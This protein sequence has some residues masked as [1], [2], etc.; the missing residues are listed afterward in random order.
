M[1]GNNAGNEAG[2]NL[3]PDQNLLMLRMRS[4]RPATTGESITESSCPDGDQC[5]NA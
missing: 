4:L 5:E 3:G 1:D 2:K